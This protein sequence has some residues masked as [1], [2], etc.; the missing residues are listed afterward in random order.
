MFHRH[1]RK[2]R[3]VGD[4][5]DAGVGD[6]VDTLRSSAGGQ[7]GDLQAS[8][9]SGQKP[10][11]FAFRYTG[12]APAAP[13]CNESPSRISHRS[14]LENQRWRKNFWALLQQ[15]LPCSSWV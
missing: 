3:R 4:R 5:S 13:L 2:I 9:L 14:R 8:G 1:F 12:K 10:L 7:G 11:T 15:P 6:S